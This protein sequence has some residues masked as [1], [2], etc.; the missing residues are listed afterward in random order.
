V[1]TES[2]QI[3]LLFTALVAVL[4][5]QLFMAIII[6]GLMYVWEDSKWPAFDSEDYDQKMMKGPLKPWNKGN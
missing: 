2:Q 1:K 4:Y 5:G 3:I 6:I